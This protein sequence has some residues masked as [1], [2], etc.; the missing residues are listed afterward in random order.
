MFEDYFSTEQA[1]DYDEFSNQLF[2]QG[3]ADT[4]ASLHGA[5]CG[6]MAAGGEREPDYYL[7]AVSQALDLDLHGA[8]AELCLRLVRTTQTALADEEFDFQLFLP[9]DEVDITIRV[10]AVGD[11]CTSFM[12][13]FALLIA[14]TDP[15]GLDDETA[16]ILKDMSAIAG[17]DADVDV[18]TGEEDEE[19]AEHSY[20]EITEYLRVATMNLYL[21]RLTNR[22]EQVDQH[23]SEN[24]SD[25]W[26]D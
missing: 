7:A 12:A 18:D 5:M 2:E 15:A 6:A 16:E 21:E 4:P 25:N 22:D 14:Q 19:E 23:G 1:L 9:D 11:W 3:L 13:G 26:A 10:A 24:N 17:V 8:L 20:F